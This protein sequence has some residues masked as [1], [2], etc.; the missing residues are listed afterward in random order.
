MGQKEKKKK[1]GAKR[2]ATESCSELDVER[3]NETRDP[4]LTSSSYYPQSP[5]LVQC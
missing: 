5:V 1:T 4:T 3:N 2:K